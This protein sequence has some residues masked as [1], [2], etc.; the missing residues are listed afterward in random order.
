MVHTERVIKLVKDLIGFDSQNPPGREK[1]IADFC[2]AYLGR[3]GIPSR[4]VA[5][6]P[7]R[8]NVIAEM[9]SGSKKLLITPHLDTVPAGRKWTHSPLKGR[10][11]GGKIFGLGATDCKCNLA[12]AMEAMVRLAEGRVRLPY[13]L[14]FAATADEETG[15]ALGLIPLLE[16]NV[17][18]V[19]AA[20]V[21][22]ADAFSIIVAQKGL[23][24]LKLSFNGV[25]AHGAYPWLGSNAIDKGMAVVEVLK[26]EI[27]GKGRHPH[28][29]PATVNVGTIRGG[30]KVNIVA[31][32]CEIELDVRFLPGTRGEDVLAR[33]K[34]IIAREARREVTLEAASIQEPYEID[35]GHPLVAGLRRAMRRAGKSARVEGSEGA[36]V[37]T[38]FQHKGIPAVATGFGAAGCA[39][40]TNEFARQADIISG[41]SV[42][43]DFLKRF[44]FGG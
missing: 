30:D 42:L 32:W 6:R 17:L 2:R 21:L 15:S 18:R 20:L 22:D 5:L 34:K 4:S 24:H 7:G 8:D 1:E 13:N 26:Q 9:G 14:V 40:M 23:M 33:V 28:L 12:C 19:D 44:T 35:V 25:R 37:I 38:F 10:L 11:Q 27:A 36:T 31:D 41:A 43:E 3:W 29:R 16:K 39:H